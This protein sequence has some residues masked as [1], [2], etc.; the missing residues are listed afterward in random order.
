VPLSTEYICYIPQN[1]INKIARR[2]E[3]KILESLLEVEIK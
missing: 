1:Q 3:G 2:V